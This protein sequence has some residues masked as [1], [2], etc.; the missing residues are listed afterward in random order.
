MIIFIVGKKEKLRTQRHKHEFSNRTQI[1]L[2]SMCLF[3]DACYIP[4]HFVHVGKDE[5]HRLPIKEALAS[6]LGI[7][8]DEKEDKESAG[9]AKSR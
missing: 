4:S 2:I 7:P 3:I 1:S 6:G 5:S 8:K 9:Q